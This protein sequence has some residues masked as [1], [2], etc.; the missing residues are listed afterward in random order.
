M[1][2]I[3]LHTHTIYSKD[4]LTRTADFLAQARALGLHKI[5]V[6][7]HNRL[8]GALAAKTLAPDLVIV[9]EEIMTTEGEIIGY[10]LSEEVPRGLTPKETIRRLRDQGA[11]ITIPHPL[12]SVRRSAMRRT[13][14]MS[15]IDEVDALEVLNARCVRNQDN[16]EAAALARQYNKLA[17]AGS[18]AHTL[19]E[20]GR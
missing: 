9:G 15:V 20:I 17:T 11:V 4:C 13:A 14:V 8:D 6:T 3:D 10:Y 12:D 1:W 7:E 2:K 19:F 5:A 18:D 16:L